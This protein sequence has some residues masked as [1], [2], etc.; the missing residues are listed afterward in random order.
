MVIPRASLSCFIAE[1]SLDQYTQQLSFMSDLPAKPIL[2]K[3]SITWPSADILQ[4]L[5]SSELLHGWVVQSLEQAAVL[6][7]KAESLEQSE[8]ASST[9]D[10]L[11]DVKSSW[12]PSVEGDWD[13]WCKSRSI[14]FSCLDSANQ[15]RS[16]ISAW[17]SAQ[18][19]SRARQ[20]FLE[21][22]PQLDQVSFS[23]LQTRDHHLAQEWYFKLGDGEASFSE[24]AQQS[25]GDEK[26]TAGRCGPTFI[27]DLQKPI[28]RLLASAKPSQVQQPLGMPSG[29][30]IL[31]RLDHRQPAQWDDE[32]RD[33]LIDDLH[34]RWLRLAFEHLRQIQPLPGAVCSIPMP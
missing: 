10:L 22:G 31:L 11:L 19:A 6:S 28:A 26:K 29:Q 24:L 12:L 23:M 15:R 8:P 4:A 18:Y 2:S 5:L 27:R 21:L 9:K 14:S 16:F 1:V 20:Q 25:L 17:K 7:F 3:V 30:T 13:E 33:L 34:K 32:M